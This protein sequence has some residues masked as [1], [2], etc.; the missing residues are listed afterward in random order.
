MHR[1]PGAPGAHVVE[2]L[3]RAEPRL[4][5]MALAVDADL[6]RAKRSRRRAPAG[7]API[8]RP[9]RR[10]RA[11]VRSASQPVAAFLDDDA[12]AERDY[13]AQVLGHSPSPG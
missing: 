5:P 8:R 2:Q 10:S 1:Q 11:P 13:I 4:Q 9:G 12:V 3:T 7:A 6:V